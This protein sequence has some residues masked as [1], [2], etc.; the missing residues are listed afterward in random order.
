MYNG[1]SSQ[2]ARTSHKEMVEI[3]LKVNK[4]IPVEGIIWYPQTFII[5]NRFLYFLLTL[6]IHVIPALIIDEILK[7]MGRQP[8]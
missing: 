7:I 6:L 2:I 1:T 3:G 8:M 4:E 5:S